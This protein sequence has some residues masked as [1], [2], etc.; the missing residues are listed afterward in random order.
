MPTRTRWPDL[1]IDA[2][3]DEFLIVCP[4]CAGRALVRDRAPAEP[5]IALS[6][7]GCGCAQHWQPRAPGVMVSADRTRYRPGSVCIGDA[8]DWYFHRPLW[9]QTGCC[10]RTLWAYNQRHLDFLEDFVQA[11]LREQPRGPHG[12]SNRSLRSRLPRW[13]AAARHRPELLQ[14]IQRLRRRLSESN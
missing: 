13:I 9:L 7:A 14:A 3:G 2:F 1:S 10:G 8:V 6:C 12:W 11:D 5:R 4:R